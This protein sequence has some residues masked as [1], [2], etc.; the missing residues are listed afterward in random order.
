MATIIKPEML[1]ASG[2]ALR[3]VAYDLTDMAAEADGYLVGVRREAAKIVEQARR[4][5]AAVRQDAEAAGR[6]AAEEAID[7]I[8]DEK[9]AQQMKT[10][11]PALQAAAQ[12]IRDSQQSWLKQWESAAVELACA[13]AARLVRG[14]LARRPEISLAWMREALELATGAGEIVIHLNPADHATLERQTA[15]LAASMHPTAKVRLAADATTSL[16]G[17]RV[18]TE[19]GTVDMQIEAQLERITQELN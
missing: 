9:V 17:C 13:I 3:H 19:F 2:T 4:D 8:L 5:G 10:L 16:G 12:Q 1:T 11:T 7:R 18:T 6:R 15:Q 14:E